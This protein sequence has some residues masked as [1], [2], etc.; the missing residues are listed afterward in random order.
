MDTLGFMLCERVMVEPDDKKAKNGIAYI[1]ALYGW[2]A[3]KHATRL[4]ERWMEVVVNV[5]D[6]RI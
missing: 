6:D 4:R 2:D 3:A 1:R 5:R